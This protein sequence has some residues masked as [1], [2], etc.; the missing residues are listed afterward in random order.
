MTVG[1]FRIADWAM[2]AG[3]GPLLASPVFTLGQVRIG[4]HPRDANYD[5]HIAATIGSSADWGDEWRFDPADKRLRSLIWSIPE[6]NANAP[7]HLGSA[8]PASL[9]LHS[10]AGEVDMP[11]TRSFTLQRLVCGLSAPLL[12]PTGYQIAPGLTVLVQDSAWWGWVLERPLEHFSDGP[13]PAELGPLVVEWF[14]LVSDDTLDALDAADPALEAEIRR[15]AARAAAVA[16]PVAETLVSRIQA[17][18]QTFFAA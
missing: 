12:R 2:V 9:R 3:E 5:R 15:L 6:V 11:A 16:S 10:L 7:S 14:T 4:P 13:A 1:S 18:L 17:L 8:R